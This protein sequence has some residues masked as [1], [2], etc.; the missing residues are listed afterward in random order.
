MS[1]FHFFSFKFFPTTFH[2]LVMDI[3]KGINNRKLFDLLEISEDDFL[4]LFTEMRLLHAKRTCPRC[5]RQMK[6]NK[7][8]DSLIWACSYGCGPNNPQN[9]KKIDFLLELFFEDARISL[10]DVSF[11]L[12]VTLRSSYY[13]T[14]GLEFLRTTKFNLK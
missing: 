8:R 2:F 11:K 5:N 6:S 9:R 14:I 10:K 3:L 4:I 13:C 1:I 12:I 7:N